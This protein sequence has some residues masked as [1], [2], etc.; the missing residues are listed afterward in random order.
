M[1]RQP[2][3]MG[4]GE[5]HGRLIYVGLGTFVCDCGKRVSK[6]LYHVRS[7]HTRSCGCMHRDAISAAMKTHGLSKSS[8][9]CAWSNMLTRCR[10]PK[11]SLFSEY[12]GRGITVCAAWQNSFEQFL[13]DVGRKPNKASI[14]D[15]ID[16]NGNYEPGNVR[17]ASPIVSARNKRSVQIVCIEGVAKTIPEWEP[18]SP[19]SRKV[20][21]R[22]LRDGWSGRDA[23][24][25]PPQST[26]K[27]VL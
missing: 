16:P 8:E 7:G 25:L 21:W 14:L 4:L 13:A 23:V 9:Y 24:F 18:T 5:R 1:P 10:N 26:K 22:R 20:I 12:G 3:P 27:H 6:P 19:V 15:R 2:K 11:Y 17:W